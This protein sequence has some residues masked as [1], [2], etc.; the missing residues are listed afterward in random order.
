M[1]YKDLG[2]RVV[3]LVGG[4]NNIESVSH[5][6]TRLRFVLKDEKI[7]KTKEIKETKGV[8][9]VMQQGG[10]YQVVI[11]NEVEKAYIEVCKVLNIVEGEAQVDEKIGKKDTIL[12]SLF[13]SITGIVSPV[14]G[15]LG[16][17]GILKGLLS[18]CVTFGWLTADAGTYKILYSFADGFFYFL[19]IILG[20]SAAIKFKS[21]P[22]ISAAIGAALV[23]PNI[24]ADYSS[25][26]S[27]TFLHI[28]VVLMNY[29]S[30][31][32]PIIMAAYVA[33]KVEKF[34]KKVLPTPLKLMFVP[35]FTA[36]IVLPL[37]FMVIGPVGTLISKGLA[38]GTSGLYTFSP[39]FAGI[40]LGA[41]WQVVVIFGLHYAFIPILINNITTMH[42]DP[43]NAI[44]SVTVFALAGTALGY[45][46][47]VKDKEKKALGFS[48]CFSALL[49]VTE[50]TI[51]GIAI[52]NKKAFISAFIGGGIAG[53]ITAGAGAAMYGFGG[54]G[55]L[56]AP[57]FINPAGIDKSFTIY[58]IASAVAFVVSAVLT[59]FVG[60]KRTEK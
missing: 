48:S 27:I 51:Y 26:A 28:P 32:F 42:K 10:Q 47:K 52:P 50:P 59:Y 60:V 41:F 37:T 6:I 35:L 4:E 23:Y 16:A 2:V 46:I 43:V 13:K 18:L 49:G 38:A 40:L 29:T 24:V 7:A 1:D 57:M 5:C 36:I 34:F 14:L 31:V 58:L 39:I 8:L 44:L 9:A 25:A 3:E 53:G 33:S 55:F 22:Y 45:A 15:V 12:N 11:G 20:F 54:G 17:A 21:N 19:P 56:A 30:S